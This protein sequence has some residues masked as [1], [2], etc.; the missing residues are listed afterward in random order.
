MLRKI[1]SAHRKVEN[2]QSDLN[3]RTIIQITPSSQRS[4]FIFRKYI[5]EVLVGKLTKTNV[6]MYAIVVTGRPSAVEPSGRERS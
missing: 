2:F 4:I 6:Y 1:Y 3:K 5:G